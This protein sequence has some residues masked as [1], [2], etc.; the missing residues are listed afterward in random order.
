MPSILL[1]DDHALFREGLRFLLESKT[2]FVVA[3]EASSGPEAVRLAAKTL[4]DFVLLD[5]A[6]PGGDGIDAIGNILQ[7][8][9]R[10]RVIALSTLDDRRTVIDMLSAGAAGY[11]LKASA[12]KDL[13]EALAAVGTGHRYLS[14]GLADILIDLALTRGTNGDKDADPFAALSARERSVLRLICEDKPPKAIAQELG[15]SRKTVD[16]HKR[17]IMAKL[18]VKS[19]LG[20]ARFAIEG[21]FPYESA[22]PRSNRGSA[23][24]KRSRDSDPRNLQ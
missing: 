24:T 12:F 2:G 3:G 18:G 11:V 10:C 16:V 17:N 8:A 6:M 1:V 9:P 7:A 4:P 20:L 23:T 22:I 5:V 19:D 15:I 14:P 13:E 21:G